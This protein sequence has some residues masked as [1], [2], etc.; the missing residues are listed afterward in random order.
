MLLIKM[1]SSLGSE[2]KRASC[3]QMLLCERHN[4]PIVQ[5]SCSGAIAFLTDDMLIWCYDPA[6]LGWGPC[7]GNIGPLS[8][9]P[10]VTALDIKFTC[11]VLFPKNFQQIP[12][13]QQSSTNSDILVPTRSQAISLF[14][15]EF[16]APRDLFLPPCLNR[17]HLNPSSRH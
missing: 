7:T 1:T 3:F 4:C 12:Y 8:W 9:A 14:L 5:A 15:Q 17:Q 10:I 13:N 11:P 6:L 16:E 2:I